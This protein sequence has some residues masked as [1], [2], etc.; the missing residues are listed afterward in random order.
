MRK[1]SSA[2]FRKTYPRLTEPY[3]I[4]V[5]GHLIGVWTPGGTPKDLS[6]DLALID[7]DEARIPGFNSVPFTPV[8]KKGK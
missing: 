7:R 6:F 3:A 2:E 4:T 1:I 8:P 5:N